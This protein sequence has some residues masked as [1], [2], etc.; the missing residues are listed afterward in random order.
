MFCQNPSLRLR[1]GVSFADDLRGDHE[2]AQAG[3]IVSQL[4]NLTMKLKNYPFGKPAKTLKE[5]Y[6]QIAALLKPLGKSGLKVD[7]GGRKK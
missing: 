5:Q 4:A 6:A 2:P 3:G 7:Q 1:I